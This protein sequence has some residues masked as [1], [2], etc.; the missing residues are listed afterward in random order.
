MWRPL[1]KGALNLRTNSAEEVERKLELGSKGSS[2]CTH[3]SKDFIVA[4]AR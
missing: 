4:I 2:I 1:T 3:W